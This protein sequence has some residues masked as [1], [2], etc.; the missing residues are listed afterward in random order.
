M[1]LTH[2]KILNQTVELVHEKNTIYLP[3]KPICDI[4]GVSIQKQSEKLKEDENFASTITLRVTV[5]DDGKQRE[6]LCLPIMY[7]PA[8]LFTISPANVK[9]EAK[10]NLI[11]YRACC[12]EV[13]ADFFINS[14]IDIRDS[15]D[16]IKDAETKIKALND[17][18]KESDNYLQKAELKD[19]I[20]K[21]RERIEKI[22]DGAQLKL[23]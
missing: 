3:I 15:L 7:V 2:I 13:L 18:Y 6:M 23:F 10:E 4:I 14:V 8:W 16:T 22:G 17:E 9:P 11:K 20:S 21:H 19:I 12:I 1:K 5:A